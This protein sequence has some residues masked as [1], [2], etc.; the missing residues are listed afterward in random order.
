MFS[1]ACLLGIFLLGIQ[2][3][4]S[5]ISIHVVDKSDIVSSAHISVNNSAIGITDNDGNAIISG[6]QI[7]DEISVSH[8]AYETECFTIKNLNDTTVVLTPKYYS[9]PESVSS[10][11]YDYDI[12]KSKLKPGLSC[13]SLKE[14]IPVAS[15]DSLIS[16]DKV[17]VL[18][19]TGYLLYLAK[20]KEPILSEYQARILDNKKSS[21][22][23]LAKEDIKKL[24]T[25]LSQE[26]SNVGAYAEYACKCK[27]YKG[28]RVEYRGKNQD[29][30]VFYFFIP[31]QD[32]GNSYKCRG[33]LYID[34]S[35]GIL[36]HIEAT[37]TS[38]STDYASYD[39]IVDYHYLEANNAILPEKI[40]GITYYLDKNG[41]IF[42]TH[43]RKIVL[44]WE[45]IN[46]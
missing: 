3:D 46:P 17:L 7:G 12:L 45:H 34:S 21:K 37:C 29:S 13:G 44:D 31:P 6:V 30:E 15:V 38:N 43:R 25:H 39:I 4:S 16:G 33:F 36:N 8:I 24:K 19:D 32:N 20:N 5:A 11:D 1:S 22:N 40:Y 14:K 2:P 18:G 28:F 41:S 26:L 23:T 10:P 9:L 35:T 42:Q 27:K